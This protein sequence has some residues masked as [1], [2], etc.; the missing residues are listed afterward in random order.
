MFFFLSLS[1]QTNWSCQLGRKFD[2]YAWRSAL[3]KNLLKQME[4]QAY[5]DS[6]YV[7]KRFDS[8]LAAVDWNYPSEQN[9]RWYIVPNVQIKYFISK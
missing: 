8:C 2:S 3:E 1:F 9:S 6:I 5:P 7:T 4:A